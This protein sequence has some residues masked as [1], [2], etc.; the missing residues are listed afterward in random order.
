MRPS[1]G[2]TETVILKLHPDLKTHLE[3]K[4]KDD[5]CTLAEYL[6]RLII[7]DMRGDRVPGS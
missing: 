4:A 6:R 7:Q 1:M 2:M 3:Q 5:Y